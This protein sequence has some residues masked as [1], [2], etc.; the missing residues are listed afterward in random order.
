M[1]NGLMN[2]SN[3]LGQSSNTQS[4]GLLGGGV[5][6]QPMSR[7]QRRSKLLTDAISGAGQNPYA[8]LGASF[9]GLI[10]MGGRAAAEG[11]GL[12]DK[13]QEVQRAEA[14]RQVQQEVAEQG[15][16]PMSN[17]AEFG[18]VVTR[19]FQE[20]N[21]PELAMRTQLQLRQMMPEQ[22]ELP[23]DFRNLTLRAQQAGLEPGTDEYR[24]FFRTGGSSQKQSQRELEKEYYMGEGFDERTATDLANNNIQISTN[25]LTG[26][27]ELVNITGGPV[28]DQLPQG[29]NANTGTETVATDQQGDPVEGQARDDAGETSGGQARRERRDEQAQ[30][31]VSEPLKVGLVPWLQE[32]LSR[33][34]GQVSDEFA[35][36]DTTE[37]RAQL[38]TARQQLISALSISGRPPVIEQERIEQNLPSLGPLESPTRARTQLKQLTSDLLRQREADIRDIDDE[39][40]NP[41]LRKEIQKRVNGV[42]K[43]L[44]IVDPR[45]LQTGEPTQPPS[46]APDQAEDIL[47]GAVSDES[48]PQGSSL[49]SYDY[50]LNAYPIIVDGKPAT[51]SEGDQIYIFDE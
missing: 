36:P 20:L 4:G 49:G 18:E 46:L 44:R 29:Y 17:P 40:I 26:Q 5:F 22:Q 25:P 31:L 39:S 14:I 32:G 2:L 28:P 19:R 7:G 41:S 43:M 51:N 33:T 45:A 30:G 1:A 48:L 42:D 8:R 47:Q 50:D 13:P 6:S 34:A 24:E 9:G 12:V 15:L 38:R 10:G 23:A 3:L 27:S 11:A 21:Q 35:F 37:D 16:D